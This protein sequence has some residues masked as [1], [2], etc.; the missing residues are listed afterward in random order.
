MLHRL[1]PQRLTVLAY[2]RIT[3]VHAAD[4]AGYAPNVSASPEMFDQQMGYL[5]RHFQVI[6]LKQLLDALERNIPLPDRAALI[7][8]DDGYR[9][10]HEQALPILR[11]HQLPATLFL[12]TDFLDTGRPFY[13]DRVA[14]AFRIC[15]LNKASLPLMHSEKRW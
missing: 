10:N 9:D 3:D 15:R 6:S 12:A 13:W 11:H 14:H 4:F 1:W 5:R 2:H 8:F 7:T